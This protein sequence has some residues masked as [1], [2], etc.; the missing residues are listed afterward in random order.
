MYDDV[1]VPTD[2]SEGVE[3]A[4]THAEAIADRFDATVHTVHVVQTPDSAD[5]LEESVVERLERAGR[6]AVDAVAERADGAGGEVHAAV[7]TGVPSEEIVAYAE[8]H[9][10]D[11]IVMSTA[12]RTGTER[13]VVGSVT[14]AV[15]RKSPVPV[16][17][18]NVG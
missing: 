4:V 15:V 13:E 7:R 18:V 3:R 1:L 11:V 10:I 6:E 17:T 14:E 2:G 9:G 5:R 8:D 12:G 16:L